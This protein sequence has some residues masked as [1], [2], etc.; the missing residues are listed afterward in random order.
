[1]LRVYYSWMPVEKSSPM[2]TGDRVKV[3][4]KHAIKDVRA[5]IF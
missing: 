1:M 5:E 4:R 3:I 2:T